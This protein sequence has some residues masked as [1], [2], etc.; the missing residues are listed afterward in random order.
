MFRVT[1]RLFLK[2]SAAAIATLTLFSAIAKPFKNKEKETEDE[3]LILD[4][5]EAKAV[6]IDC[7]DNRFGPSFRKLREELKLAE[8]SFMELKQP[9]GPA[10]L[11]HPDKLPAKFSELKQ[12]INFI[13]H[14]CPKISTILLIG[15]TECGFYGQPELKG[16]DARKDLYG[17]K[18]TAA[19]LWPEKQIRIWFVSRSNSDRRRPKF[20]LL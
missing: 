15:H 20:E 1:R 14:H 11:A 2:V 6:I 5:A 4:G 19:Q 18:K 13:L 8:G 9:G 7:V 3:V 10:A 12:D 17:A 16:Q